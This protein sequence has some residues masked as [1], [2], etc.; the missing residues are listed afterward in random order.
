MRSHSDMILMRS[1]KVLQALFSYDDTGDGL[2]NQAK[3]A[4]SLDFSVALDFKIKKNA[5]HHDAHSITLHHI[6]QTK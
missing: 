6:S 5:D 4:K 3:V 2:Q 1:R